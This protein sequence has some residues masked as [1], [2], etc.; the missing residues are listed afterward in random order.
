[1]SDFICP[2]CNAWIYAPLPCEARETSNPVALAA[3]C[4]KCGNEYE[5]TKTSI[6]YY[7]VRRPYQIDAAY[8]D[9]W[10]QPKF[11]LPLPHKHRSKNHEE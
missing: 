5:F 2:H 9:R 10:K 7:Q 3:D 6:G 8:P 11:N 1:M 4:P